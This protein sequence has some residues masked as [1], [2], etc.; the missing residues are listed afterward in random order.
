M[1]ATLW[2]ALSGGACA[3]H[4][5]CCVAPPGSG[6]TLAYALPLV[7]SLSSRVVRRLR[8]LVV[9]PTHDLALQVGDVLRPLCHAAGLSLAVVSGKGAL[10]PEAASLV[11][12]GCES[13]VD[14]LV[15]TPGRQALALVM[16]SLVLTRAFQARGALAVHAGLHTGAPAP[17]GGGRGGQAAAAGLPGAQGGSDA[18]HS[19]LSR[20]RRTGCL[21]SSPPPR[22]RRATR[23]PGA[24]PRRRGCASAPAAA[25]WA[26]ARARARPRRAFSSCSSPQP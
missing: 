22:P 7:A 10:A 21:S 26:A 14:V 18:H 6:K 24:L 3:A 13:R 4:D 23:P 19:P 20:A 12:L 8:A 11:E 9:L 5:V 16:V 17:V 1:Q 15:A 25:S 2:K